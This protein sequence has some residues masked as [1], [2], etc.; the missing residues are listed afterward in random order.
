MN[1]DSIE[2]MADFDSAMR[3]FDSFRSSQARLAAAIA[4]VKWLRAV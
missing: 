2:V 4:N 3:R 1:I